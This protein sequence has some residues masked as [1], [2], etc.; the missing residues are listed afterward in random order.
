METLVPANQADAQQA[1][2][3]RL[4]ALHGPVDEFVAS[5]LGYDAK[6]LAKYFG[7]EQVDAIGLAIGNHKQGAGFIIGDQ[8]GVGKGRVNAAMLRYANRQGLVPVFVTQSADLFGDIVRDLSDIGD[9]TAS[10][11]FEA[12]VLND[13]SGSEAIKRPDGKVFQASKEVALSRLQEAMQNMSAGRGFVADVDGKPTAFHAVFL[14]Y[15][16]LQTVKG[17]EPARRAVLR[18]LA[19]RTYLLLDESHN[20]GGVPKQNERFK[21]KDK[22]DAPENRAELIRELVQAA[23]GVFYSSATFAKRPDVMDLYSRTDM[24]QAVGGDLETLVQAVAAGGVPLQQITSQ[25]LVE[26]GQ[27]LRREKSFDGITI[28]SKVVSANLKEADSIA[29]IFRRLRTFDKA[30]AEVVA[31][32]EDEIV[33]GGGK[34]MADQA[35]GQPSFTSTN[36]SSLLW[37]A[38]DQMLMSMKADQAANEAIEA[39][40][41]GEKPVIAVDNTMESLLGE[42]ASEKGLDIGSSVNLSFNDI[43]RRYLDRSRV[44]TIKSGLKGEKASKQIITDEELDRDTSVGN[45]LEIYNAIKREIAAVSLTVPASPI[46]WIRYRMEQAGMRVTE[47]TGRNLTMRYSGEGQATL[48]QRNRSERGVSGKQKS[49]AGFNNGDVDAL[50]LNRSGAT[51]LSIHASEKFK[52]QRARHMIIA[53]PAKNIDEFMQMLGRI[54]RTG[55]VKK[56]AKGESVLPR[57][58]LLMTDSPAE[59][60]PAS[61]L[62]KKMASL[63]ANVT[64]KSKGNIA[65]DAPD[66][67]NE[68]GGRVI[69]EYLSE[70]EELRQELEVEIPTDLDQA[71]SEWLEGIARKVTGKMAALPVAEQRDI[72]DAITHE[73]DLRIKQLDAMNQNPLAASTLPLDART[74]ERFELFK[75]DVTGGPFAQPAYLERLDAKVQGKPLS[76]TE[77]DDALTTFYATDDVA[78]LTS[79]SKAWQQK[80]IDDLGKAVGAYKTVVQTQGKPDA[81]KTRLDVLDA[82]HSMV[83]SAIQRFSPGTTVS[84]R[85]DLGS[86]RGVVVAVKVP[87]VKADKN[88]AAPSK[89]KFQ[90]A[91]DDAA[92]TLTFSAGQMKEKASALKTPEGRPVPLESVA[93][94]FEQAQSVSRETRWVASG[95]VLAAFGK[96]SEEH[97]NITFYTDDRGETRSGILLPKSFSA[98]AYLEQ[99]PVVIDNAGD[100][101]KFFD[102]GGIELKTPDDALA[103]RRAGDRLVVT[104]LEAKSR[105][106]RYTTNASILSAARPHEFVSRGQRMELVVPYDSGSGVVEAVLSAAGGLQATSAGDRV[107]AR[108]ALGLSKTGAP[109][110][111]GRTADELVEVADADRAER[112]PDTRGVGIVP[113]SMRGNT[114]RQAPLASEILGLGTDRPATKAEIDKLIATDD[115][116]VDKRKEIANGIP[117]PGLKERLSGLVSEVV[118]LFRQYKKIPQ[119]KEF[120]KYI[121]VLRLHETRAD[122]VADQVTRYLA[123]ILDPIPPSVL[124]VFTTKL[125]W[126]NEKNNF[127]NGQYVHYGFKSLAEIENEIAKVDKVIAVPSMSAVRESLKRREEVRRDIAQQLVDRKLSQK[128]IIDNS[129]YFHQQVLAYQS[130][131]RIA[132]GT[133]ATPAPLKRGFQIARKTNGAKDIGPEFDTNSNYL[134]AEAAWMTDALIEIAKYDALKSLGNELPRLKADTKQ[135]N[136]VA[137]VG[138]PDN[139]KRIED[140]RKRMDELRE[141]GN[142]EDNK[143]ELKELSK[144]L[145]ELDPTMP[146]RQRMA[147]ALA[148]MTKEADRQYADPR[149]TLL[150]QANALSEAPEGTRGQG[151]A[152]GFLS[153][154]QEREA[155]IQ[156]RLGDEYLTWQKVLKENPKLA[157]WAIRPKHQFFRTLGLPAKAQAA[158]MAQVEAGITDGI[159]VKLEDLKELWALRGQA[160]PIVLPK[161]VVAELEDMERPKPT[162]KILIALSSPNTFLR[163]LYTVGHPVIT[164]F[165]KYMTG[166]AVGDAEPVIMASPEIMLLVPAATKAMWRYTFN[167]NLALP[168]SVRAAR[169]HNVIGATLAKASNDEF[170]SLPALGRFMRQEGGRF[171]V[172]DAIGTP[173]RLVAQLNEMR[174]SVLRY[175]AFLHYRKQLRNGTLKHYGRANPAFVDEIQR[176]LGADAAAAHLARNLVGDPFA[177]TQLGKFLNKYIFMFWRFQ[178]TALAGA[179][180]LLL[181]TVRAGG[182]AGALSAGATIAMRLLWA[183]TFFSASSIWN[184][185]MFP[186][187]EEQL[188]VD[189]KN[190]AHLIL[191]RNPDGSIIL[192]RNFS[193]MGAAFEW[194]GLMQLPQLMREHNDG[195]ITLKQLSTEMAHAPF[196]KAAGQIRADAKGIYEGFTGTSI[197]PDVFHPRTVDPD[198]TLAQTFGLAEENRYLQGLVW[199][200][201]HR[202]R[203]HYWQRTLV[204]V[205]DPREA[206]ISDMHDL[207]HKFDVMKS[208]DD[209]APNTYKT[210]PTKIMR[211]AASSEDFVAFAEAKAAYLKKA[212]DKAQADYERQKT[213]G[214]DGPSEAEHIAKARKKAADA[215]F[216]SLTKLDPTHHRLS[217]TAE[218]EFVEDFLTAEQVTKLNYARDFALDLQARMI[219]WWGLTDGAN[220]VDGELRKLVMQATDPVTLKEKRAGKGET[221]TDKEATELLMQL[222]VKRKQALLALDQ[223]YAETY[224]RNHPRE[225]VRQGYFERND[226]YYRHRREILKMFPAD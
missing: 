41:R 157:A 196:N 95:N 57:F 119:S 193:Q 111:G 189:D 198:T 9:N 125:L 87:Q 190:S 91:I 117:K 203:P 30:I 28:A 172:I 27:Y 121:E 221:N 48:Q 223:K 51:G 20:A 43:L 213:S 217:D 10:Q 96:L 62:V 161:E 149:D 18:S 167:Q 145:W 54:N 83:V 33:G 194:L 6:E 16:Q 15:S 216:T 200:E 181:N 207:R 89:W 42:Y 3:D 126:E 26:S 65:F 53:Q 86:F 169:D 225:H 32:L 14:T 50:I 151:P 204:G 81:V 7:G 13:T 215:Y 5:E 22:K 11:P 212:T 162:S 8:T 21:G 153:A 17:A 93:K 98:N 222:G 166:N 122:A 129:A 219:S 101:A 148:K 134:E 164:K 110:S 67:L 140:I 90:V 170:R 45:A 108:T 143:A 187:E 182:K 109:A 141:D 107:T 183:A 133:G 195:Q 116:E 82:M 130:A 78:D 1:A 103:I 66:V 177:I 165:F 70:N 44:L 2:L 39:F 178:E 74:K 185:L 79:K 201:G 72:W 104:S 208:G 29:T 69:A 136:Y 49:I 224:A 220:D 94:E 209:A 40:K 97:G 205:V 210:S 31:E 152:R 211:N 76:E 34:I 71:G 73:Y 36:F 105:G 146:F 132:D 38:V 191:G 154:V 168:E 139:M 23:N 226:S 77:L 19:P 171:N 106:K 135:R 4:E 68:V 186:D 206:A 128:S 84:I 64:A 175:A 35:V 102:A 47:V 218:K 12:I 100:A 197:Y 176:T 56:N 174:E 63:N 52:D 160:E 127:L 156:T 24:A 113:A 61:V 59:I 112:R 163:W 158:L 37:N 55:Q 131:I 192:M 138:G 142:G 147:I 199:G 155:D 179:P 123:S 173:H 114:P 159:N 184:Q 180:R 58:T 124:N 118:G 60:R 188:N 150:E 202:P 214:K 144:E 46:D 25:M 92:R 75:G 88:P 80:T 99:R 120:S 137:V 85:T 115:P